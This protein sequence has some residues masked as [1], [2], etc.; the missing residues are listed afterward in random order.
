VLD[1]L[2]GN[3]DP[4]L[5]ETAYAGILGCWSLVEPDGTGHNLYTHEPDG[6]LYDPWTSEMGVALF[7]SIES[8]NAYVINDPDFGI[9]GYGCDV[10]HR[11]HKTIITPR[12]ETRRNLIDLIHGVAV[13]VPNGTISRMVVGPDPTVDVEAS[14]MITNQAALRVEAKTLSGKPL[15][16]S[17][18]VDHHRLKSIG[19]GTFTVQK[20]LRNERIAL[21]LE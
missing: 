1:E 16:A 7:A 19:D 13:S 17:L 21:N 5:L 9:T 12:D 15:E 6:M 4:R 10:I 20:P 2:L 8:M 11:R 3:P 18:K 14:P